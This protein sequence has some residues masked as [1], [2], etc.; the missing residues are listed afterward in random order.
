VVHARLDAGICGTSLEPDDAEVRTDVDDLAAALRDHDARGG[1]AGEEHALERRRDG[2][3]EFL[4]GHVEGRSGAGPPGVVDEDVDSSERV[5][6]NIY[7]AAH[8][9]H[10]RDVRELNDARSPQLLDLGP[11]LIDLV[12][13]SFGMLGQYEVRTRLGEPECDGAADAL[14]GAGHNRDLVLQAEARIVDAHSHD[15]VFK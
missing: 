9:V 6:R 14:R 1:L 3:V 12:L 15:S 4:F 2:P 13:A 11:D 7:H 8:V 10:L 5:F